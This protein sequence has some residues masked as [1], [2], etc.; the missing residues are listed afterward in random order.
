LFSLNA[1][2]ALLTAPAPPDPPP[3]R[4]T[5]MNVSSG[6][7]SM[8]APAVTKNK[9]LLI[10]GGVAALLLVAIAGFAFSGGDKE[11]ATAE[12]PSA[13]APVAAAEAPKVEEKKEEPKAEAKPEE[14][15]EEP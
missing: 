15:K 10:G 8:R 4:A 6:T 5:D 7:L 14:K 1:N 2:Q 11:E 13:S 12:A 3:S 9:T